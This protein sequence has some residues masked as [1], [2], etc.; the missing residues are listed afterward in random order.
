MEARPTTCQCVLTFTLSHKKGTGK[1]PLVGQQ[2]IRSAEAPV[3][4]TGIVPVLVAPCP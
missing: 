3:E 4:V 1:R 2:A